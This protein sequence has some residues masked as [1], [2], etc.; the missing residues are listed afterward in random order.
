MAS[1]K[2]ILSIRIAS[3]GRLLG[4]SVW[5]NAFCNCCSLDFKGSGWRVPGWIGTRGKI[6]RYLVTKS[7]LPWPT[8]EVQR[9]SIRAEFELKNTEAC[10]DSP[11]PGFRWPAQRMWRKRLHFR[12]LLQ[13][14]TFSNQL[15]Q[16]PE[17]GKQIE[18]SDTTTNSIFN[19]NKLR[20]S[21]EPKKME[22]TN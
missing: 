14:Q 7:H 9:W 4:G 1:F 16:T 17:K 21:T 8:L 12:S 18:Q 2:A 6:L 19:S 10:W 15:W 3:C 13:P 22:L 11:K 5:A 20:I